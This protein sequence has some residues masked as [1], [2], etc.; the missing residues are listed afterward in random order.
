MDNFIELFLESAPWL[1]LGLVLAGLLKV[2]VPMSW[3][4]KQLGAMASRPLSRRP[5]WARLCRCVP[6][7][8]SRP[9][10]A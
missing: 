1:L 8:L 3:M 10:L 4:Q 5:C 7:A 6:A 9:P 2:F